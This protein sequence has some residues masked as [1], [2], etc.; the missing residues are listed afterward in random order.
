MANQDEIFYDDNVFV[1]KN[2]GLFQTFFGKRNKPFFKKKNYKHIYLKIFSKK[3]LN[4]LL[5][6]TIYI[7]NDVFSDFLVKSY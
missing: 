3:M 1:F 2:Q 7:S 6:S 4:S 5:R